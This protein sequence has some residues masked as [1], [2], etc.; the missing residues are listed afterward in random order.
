VA[1]FWITILLIVDLL[2][3]IY[4]VNLARLSIGV[5]EPSGHLNVVGLEG[6]NSSFCNH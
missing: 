1:R 2:T 5:K 4:E 3:I 6:F